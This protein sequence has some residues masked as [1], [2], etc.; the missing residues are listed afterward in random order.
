PVTLDPNTAHSNLI[1]SD[2]LTSVRFSDEAKPLPDNLERFDCW[3]CVLGS[4]GFDSGLH[5]WDIEVKDLTN[6]TFGVMTESVQRKGDI[7]TKKGLWVLGYASGEYYPFI[8]PE[9]SPPLPVNKTLQKIR[10]QLNY[11]KGK[12]SFIDP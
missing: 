2:D 4:E 12:L 9:Q 5:C 1:V 7:L 8:T 11:D 3:E 6:W 10:V